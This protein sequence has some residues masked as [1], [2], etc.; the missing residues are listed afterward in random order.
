M[1]H[2]AGA[3]CL[4]GES[5]PPSPWRRFSHRLTHAADAPR[6][7]AHDVEREVRHLVD[8][9]TEFALIGQ[10]ELA[11]VLDSGRRTLSPITISS[12]PDCTMYMQEPG[13]PFVNTM[14]PAG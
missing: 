10:G 5:R 6:H 4:P 7:G 1:A 12:T 2:V 13:S 14:S 9:E 8:H 11:R 3:R